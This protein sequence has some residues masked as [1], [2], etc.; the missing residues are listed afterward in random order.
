MSFNN[1]GCFFQKVLIVILM[2]SF[3][4]SISFLINF[5]IL[6]QRSL[7]FFIILNFITFRKKKKKSLIL[8][9]YANVGP[10]IAGLALRPCQ[11]QNVFLFDIL[12][13]KRN[14]KRQKSLNEFRAQL[15]TFRQLFSSLFIQSELQVKIWMRGKSNLD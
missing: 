2:S 1:L 8:L 12:L 5:I 9:L 4:Y 6:F 13:P 15:S 11:K 3:Y 10:A 7:L 14:G